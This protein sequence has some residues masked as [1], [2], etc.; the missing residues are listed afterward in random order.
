[1]TQ[2]CTSCGH[3]H[4]GPCRFREDAH[5]TCP[6]PEFV[7]ADAQEERLRALHDRQWGDNYFGHDLAFEGC[8][9][10]AFNRFA[11]ASTPRLVVDVELIASA[12]LD[13]LVK[14]IVTHLLTE[15]G[16][17]LTVEPIHGA[18]TRPAPQYATPRTVR[19]ALDARQAE[20]EGEK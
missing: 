9:E 2:S 12:L 17:T 15:R 19:A 8:A 14:P 5:H 18:V 11:L 13:P 1:M 20:P 3:E 6:C 7:P 4:D 16:H 10:C